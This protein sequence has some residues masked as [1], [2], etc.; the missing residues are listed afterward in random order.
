LRSDDSGKDRKHPNDPPEGTTDAAGNRVVE[1]V[2]EDVRAVLDELGTLTE[3]L[4]EET[5]SDERDIGET[6]GAL[7]ELSEAAKGEKVSLGTS[8]EEEEEKTH[9]AKRASTPVMQRITPLR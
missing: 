9:F 2:G 6:D 3:V 1:D 5:R 8:N 4:K 7:A